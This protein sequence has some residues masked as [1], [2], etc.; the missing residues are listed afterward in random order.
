MIGHLR[1]RRKEK[2]FLRNVLGNKL[3]KRRIEISSPNRI[4]MLNRRK[5]YFET[6][7]IST[8]ERLSVSIDL[9]INRNKFT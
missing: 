6:N 4:V 3:S 7:D 1:E 5:L 9:Y 2:D 8:S